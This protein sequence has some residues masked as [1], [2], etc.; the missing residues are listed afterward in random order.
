MLI[1]TPLYIIDNSLSHN[2]ITGIPNKVFNLN[3]GKIKN[4]YFFKCQALIF[5][6]K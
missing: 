1:N 6:F 5:L 3:K 2:V 4:L